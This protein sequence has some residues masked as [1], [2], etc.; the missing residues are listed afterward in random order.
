[1]PL[2]ECHCE[3]CEL[4][5]EV[6]ASLSAATKSHPCPACGRRARRVISSVNFGRGEGIASA[7]HEGLL[8]PNDVTRL[9]VPPPAQICWMDQ[10]SSARYAAHLNGRGGEYDETVA[11]RSETRKKG[12]EP[13]PVM[14]HSAHEHSPLSN[15]AVYRRRKDA[16]AKSAN[17]ASSSK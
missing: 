13:E 3:R 9:K 4:T 10:P 14:T 15:P 7:S 5:F 11:A 6:L 16:A 12:G 8:G 17:K 2:Y 1:M